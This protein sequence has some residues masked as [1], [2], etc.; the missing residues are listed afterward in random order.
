M[1]GGDLA[2]ERTLLLRF[3]AAHQAD[4]EALWRAAAD[5][6]AAALAHLAH[7]I[8]G[9]ALMIGADRLGSASLAL[10]RAALEQDWSAIDTALAAWKAAAAELE[11]ELPR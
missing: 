1:S 7:R 9:A 5:R 6:D 3:R 11:P 2:L 4:A 8:L 10:G